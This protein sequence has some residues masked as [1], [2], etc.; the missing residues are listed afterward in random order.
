MLRVWSHKHDTILDIYAGL[1]SVARACR[2]ESRHY[3]GAEICPVRH[4]SA[5]DRLALQTLT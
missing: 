2:A 1:G 4:R 5:I 3:I